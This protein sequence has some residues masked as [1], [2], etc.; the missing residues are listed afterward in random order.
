ML[1]KIE[2]IT[3]TLKQAREKKKLSQRVLGQKVGLPQS[4]ISHIEH[5]TVDL[6]TSSLIELARV[7]D[8]ELML[9]P[10]S[11]LN[12]VK[13][14]LSQRTAKTETT[15]APPAYQLDEDDDGEE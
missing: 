4:H 11:M 2:H 14:L 6:K 13:G 5:N 8:L 15:Q 9:I 10:R 3:R 12:T 1:F 7:L